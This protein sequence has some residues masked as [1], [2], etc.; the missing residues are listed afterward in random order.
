[1]LIINKK[2]KFSVIS[3]ILGCFY[4]FLSFV[5]LHAYWIGEP[6]ESFLSLL[7]TIY[8]GA[9]TWAFPYIVKEF[10]RFDDDVERI[11]FTIFEGLSVLAYF[12]APFIYFY[13][14]FFDPS[15]E[16]NTED[17]QRKNQREKLKL[18]RTGFIIGSFLFFFTVVFLHNAWIGPFFESLL[19]ILVTIY[20]GICIWT[21][22]CTLKEMDHIIDA[23]LEKSLGRVILLFVDFGLYLISPFVFIQ[24]KFFD[25]KQNS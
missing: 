2:F 10:E 22:S 14:K 15:N 25:K 4:C 23:V 21:F 9:C 7:V 3:F 18:S 6:F 11:G 19:S 17:N 24:L 5:L 16:E 20:L 1:M 13:L 8:L 12:A